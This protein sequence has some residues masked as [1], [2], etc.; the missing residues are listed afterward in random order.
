MSDSW[1]D[2]EAPRLVV[3]R[4]LE[5]RALLTAQLVLTIDR[6]AYTIDILVH[7]RLVLHDL[8][9]RGGKHHIA[10]AIKCQFLHALELEH[11]AFGINTGRDNEVVFELPLF[12]VVDEIDAGIDLGVLDPGVVGNCAVPFRR[13]V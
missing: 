7:D 1:I 6:Y 9:R 13:I 2:D 4:N 11:D 3:T 12:A 5:A 8:A 10:V